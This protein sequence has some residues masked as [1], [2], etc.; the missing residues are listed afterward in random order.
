MIKKIS[1]LVMFMIMAVSVIFN[2]CAKKSDVIRIATDATWPPMESVDEKTKQ[3][4]GF[5][6]DFINAVAKEGNLKIEIAPIIY[7]KH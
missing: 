3:I 6:I 2:A 4:V 5:D 7:I 1:I